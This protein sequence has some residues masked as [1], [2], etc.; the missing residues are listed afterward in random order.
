MLQ[1]GGASREQS[2]VPEAL[3]G[4]GHPL[5]A[6]TRNDM[7]ARL[8]ADLSGVRVHTDAAAQR[9]ARE[10]GARAYTAGN[11]VVIGRDGADKATLAHELTH[12]IQQRR[13]Q[14]AGT[15]TDHGFAVSDPDDRFE[16]E[17]EANASRVM[18]ASVGSVGATEQRPLGTIPA[19]PVS[20]PVVQ[21]AMHLANYDERIYQDSHNP[22]AEYAFVKKTDGR[23]LFA[24]YGGVDR[25]TAAL[26]AV[27]F[28][29]DVRSSALDDFI[30]G[31][32]RERG[33]AWRRLWHELGG[34]FHYDSVAKT[35]NPVDEEA[36]GRATPGLVAAIIRHGPQIWN[37][38][39]GSRVPR[40]EGY[41]YGL[42]LSG[43]QA[44][45][46]LG[47]DEDTARHFDGVRYESL[48]ERQY[49]QRHLLFKNEDNGANFFEYEGR[50][51]GDRTRLMYVSTAGTVRAAAH[52]IRI[53]NRR[54][55][56][57]EFFDPDMDGE[58]QRALHSEYARLTAPRPDTGWVAG[59]ELTAVDRGAGQDSAM[60]GWNALGVVA[61]AKRFLGAPYELEQNWEWL[62]V[63]GAQIGGSTDA[64]NLVA[65][66]YVTNS[67][68]IPYEDMIAKWARTDAHRFWARFEVT[69]GG[70]L[71]PDRIRLSIKSDD[72]RDLGTLPGLV[73]AEFDPLHGRIVDRL[74]GEITK[75]NVDA[76]RGLYEPG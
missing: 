57:A 22:G 9:S 74:A 75:R 24:E 33:S 58:T 34:L 1:A 39:G 38:S 11:H 25:L 61:Y 23:L 51:P 20:T 56:D 65:G 10:I 68:M 69:P 17:A 8:G 29:G 41:L 16:R 67:A 3:R 43:D 76:T 14:V 27:G 49:E 42:D 66:T 70:T 4:G 60:N 7:E 59:T 19:P 62:H 13:G 15:D 31:A 35:T 63:Q 64:T 46:V 6:A 37:N 12:V 50:F 55:G 47:I 26:G 28:A 44:R 54:F 18:S 32:Y 73:L 53:A 40:A 5:D 72:H 21:R 45:H 2:A 48:A 36:L 71:F 52:R 30:K